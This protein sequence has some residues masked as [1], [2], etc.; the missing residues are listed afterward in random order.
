MIDEAVPTRQRLQQRAFSEKDRQ[1]MFDAD[2]TCALCGNAI[3]AIEDAQ[4]DHIKP[5]SKGGLT[6]RS[7]AQ[8]AHAFCNQSKGNREGGGA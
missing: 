2:P 3:V 5:F 1:E 7:N 8:L 6:E 4:V